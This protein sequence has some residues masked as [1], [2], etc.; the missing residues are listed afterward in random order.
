LRL[1]KTVTAVQNHAPSEAFSVV[2]AYEDFDSGRRAMDACKLLVSQLG[3]EV[4]LRSSMWKFEVLE[5]TKLNR[6]ATHDAIEADMIIVATAR[7]GDLPGPVKAWVESWVPEKRGQTAA[8]LALM[9]FTDGNELDGTN[10]TRTYLRSAATA[11]G[12]DFLQQSDSS[13][14]E[15][16][17]SP[18]AAAL[19]GTVV[20]LRLVSRPA[21]E[22]WGLND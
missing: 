16:W 17:K 20:P 21:P 4:H 1:P 15:R 12:I 3:N 9:V 22:G 2:I 8:L 14:E 19:G 6:I 11:A 7:N 18:T 10:P 13:S 5:V